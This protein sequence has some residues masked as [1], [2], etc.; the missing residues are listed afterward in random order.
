MHLVELL[1]LGGPELEE[2][3]ASAYSLGMGSA[4]FLDI[5]GV[6]NSSAWFEAQQEQVNAYVLD[7][8]DENKGIDPDA[9]AHLNRIVQATGAI[10]VISS[11][12]RKLHS[13]PHIERLLHYR[14]FSHKGRIIGA[15]PD[16]QGGFMTPAFA[17]FIQE[18][19]EYRHRYSNT[20]GNEIQAW[21]DAVPGVQSLVILDDDDDMA[22]LSPLLVKTDNRIG[23]TSEDADRA[24]ARLVYLGKYE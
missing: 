9:V 13:L 21:L 22:H 12:W 10:I 16:L 1:D 24:I 3:P 20:R 19:P 15:T 14:G 6:L 7:P 17:K 2:E 5:D 18:N 4:L 8:D 11:T 23:L